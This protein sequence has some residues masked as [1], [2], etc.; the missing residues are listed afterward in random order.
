MAKPRPVLAT[1]IRTPKTPAA[2][3]QTGPHQTDYGNMVMKT[4][5]SGVKVVESIII[6]VSTVQIQLFKCLLQFCILIVATL[7]QI[8]H[9]AVLQND[10]YEQTL[11]NDFKNPFYKTARI[12]AALKQSSWLGPGEELVYER[13]AEK[14]PRSQIYSVLSHAGLIPRSRQ[15]KRSL[16]YQRL[17]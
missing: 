14:I 15:Q 1:Y 17:V 8:Q 4:N 16:R 6:I 12:N 13:Q 5:L 3:H 2:A 7:A 9:K 10:A 11:S